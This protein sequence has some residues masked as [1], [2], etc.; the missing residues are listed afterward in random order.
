[1]H[2][3]RTGKGATTPQRRREDGA[4]GWRCSITEGGGAVRL[5]YWQLRDGSVELARVG[6]HDD[7]SI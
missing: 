1:V 4:T 2:E 7:S 6:Y 5:H 3:L